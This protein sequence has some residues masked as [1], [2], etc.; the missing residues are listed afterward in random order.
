VK[1][2]YQLLTF[3]TCSPQFY[4]ESQWVTT[5]RSTLDH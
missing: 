2:Q 5:N 4:K 3:G 1:W